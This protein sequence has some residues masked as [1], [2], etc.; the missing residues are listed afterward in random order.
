M[1][2][3]D[4]NPLKVP[5]G[6]N[7]S[8][9]YS[10]RLYQLSERYLLKFDAKCGGRIFMKKRCN[11]CTKALNLYSSWKHSRMLKRHPRCIKP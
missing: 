8:C 11:G 2:H 4:R 6:F 9:P 7:E 1:H 5:L 3:F 10:L